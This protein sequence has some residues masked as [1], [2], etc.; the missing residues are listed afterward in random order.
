MRG[1]A[2]GRTP[3]WVL[4]THTFA[5]G[6]SCSCVVA[7]GAM[8]ALCR[9]ISVGLDAK[10]RRLTLEPQRHCAF[11]CQP[12]TRRHWCGPSTAAAGHASQ[13]RCPARGGYAPVQHCRRALQ[14]PCPRSGDS[15]H[16]VVAH[17]AACRRRLDNRPLCARWLARHGRG[18]RAQD[19]DAVCV[20]RGALGYVGDRPF[21]CRPT[22]NV[23][24]RRASRGCRRTLA[25]LEGQTCTITHV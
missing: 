15:Q 12:R 17:D 20:V 2:V 6:L 11:V 7:V 13:Y 21:A 16:R 3:R 23:A 10:A 8:Q 1:I 5:A 25:Q 22:G 24:V 4:E 14:G 19:A 18:L 9:S